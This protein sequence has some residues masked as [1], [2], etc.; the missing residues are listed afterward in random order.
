[1]LVFRFLFAWLYCEY[2]FEA[3]GFPVLS[4]QNKCYIFIIKGYTYSFSCLRKWILFKAVLRWCNRRGYIFEYWPPFPL[5]DDSFPAALCGQRAYIIATRVATPSLS[6]AGAKMATNTETVAAQR[7]LREPN[8]MYEMV[9][10]Q[11]AWYVTESKARKQ[12]LFWQKHVGVYVRFCLHRKFPS[13][14]L[15]RVGNMATGSH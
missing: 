4:F 6:A 12:P 11:P 14:G 7:P 13:R 8:C 10:W 3:T 5:P 1:M 2:C 9:A 15:T